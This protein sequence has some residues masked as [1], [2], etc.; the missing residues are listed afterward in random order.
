MCNVN[1]L[2]TNLKIISKYYT[3]VLISQATVEDF[4]TLVRFIQI[5]IRY[6]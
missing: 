1:F 6:K 2:R 4:K 5:Q 3:E